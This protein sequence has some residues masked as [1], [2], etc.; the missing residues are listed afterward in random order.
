MLPIGRKQYDVYP[1][2]IEVSP[3]YLFSN[4]L[5]SLSLT[6]SFAFL[7]PCVLSHPL[8]IRSFLFT[9]FQR[10]SWLDLEIIIVCSL[11]H[12]SHHLSLQL[13]QERSSDHSLAQW[14]SM[15][16]PRH[17]RFFPNSSVW[18][19][20]SA[21]EPAKLAL[22]LLSQAHLPRSSLFSHESSLCCSS[23]ILSLK[24]SSFCKYLS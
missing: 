6:F 10:V 1:W 16:L 12:F 19:T 7:C 13:Q 22:Q 24:T 20:K 17:A 3:S 8:S 15:A 14:F 2:C 4:G 23:G 11:R 5:F 21:Q 9:L 18:A